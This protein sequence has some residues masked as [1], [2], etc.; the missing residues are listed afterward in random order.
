[1]TNRDELLQELL[2]ALDEDEEPEG[3]FTLDQLAAAKNVTRDKMRW[4]VYVKVRGGVLGTKK[5]G[6][7]RYYYKI[8]EEQQKGE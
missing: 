5:I 3:M 4:I 2:A 1:M 6:R 7:R 8:A